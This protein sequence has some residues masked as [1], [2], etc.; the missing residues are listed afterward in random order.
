MKFHVYLIQVIIAALMVVVFPIY[1]AYSADAP[2]SGKTDLSYAE[3]TIKKFKFVP[4]EITIKA[5]SSIR[6]TNREKRQYH[7]VWFEK[8]GEEE[9]DYLFPEDTYVRTFNKTGSFPYRCGP[10]PKMTGVVHVN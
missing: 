5:G 4:Q 8:L 7:N 2:V 10:H 3:V 6:W 9:P 1:F